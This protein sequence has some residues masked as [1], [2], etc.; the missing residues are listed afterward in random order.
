M[1][2]SKGNGKK[3]AMRYF[4]SGANSQLG[5][6]IFEELRNDHIAIQN[7][8]QEEE[9]RFYVT[10]NQ[11]D[12]NTIAL[13]STSMKILNSRTKPRTFKKKILSCDLL[14]MDMLGAALNGSLD[15]IEKVVKV[16]KD[17]HSEQKSDMKEQTLVLVSTVMTWIDTPKK[18]SKNPAKEDESETEEDKASYFSDQDYSQRVPSPKYQ[19]IKTIEIMAMAAQRLSRYLRV[20]VI[21]SG[22]P[23]GNG[24]SNDI[25]YEFYRSAWL[26]LHPELASLPIVGNGKNRIPTIHINDLT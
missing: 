26:S 2:E 22:L 6:S 19:Q 18:V 17:H 9:H 13:P 1:E 10:V 25:F 12:I 8:S 15:D 16:I 3:P 5:H 24:E 7:D 21:C 20:F 14:V 11:K 4:M 23:Y